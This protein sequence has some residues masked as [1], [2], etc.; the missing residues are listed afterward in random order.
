MRIDFISDISCPWCALG[1]ASLEKALAQLGDEISYELYFQ[2]FE[3]NV[4]MPREGKNLVEYL[5][6]KYGMSAEM[7][8]ASHEQLRSRGQAVGFDFGKREFIWNTFDAHRLL[9]WAS[10]AG[11]PKSQLNLKRALVRAYHT[12]A[13]NPSDYQVLINLVVEV[14][15][16][17]AE[18]KKILES[19]MY[20]KDVRRL[21]L[22]WH[23]LGINA[24]PSMVINRKKLL[25]GALPVENLVNALRQMN[26]EENN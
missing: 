17:P 21:E 3:L 14:G 8:A 11:A 1:L 5:T 6:E 23:Q 12:L 26:A 22:E 7:V 24:V 2:P 16:D 13:L 25:Q 9:F 4:D 18:A 10:I 15:L 19:D 20:T